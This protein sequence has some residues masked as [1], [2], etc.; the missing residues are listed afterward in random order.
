MAVSKFLIADL[1]PYEPAVVR[2]C[3]EYFAKRF[4]SGQLVPPI[5]IVRFDG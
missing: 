3:V 5:K 1:Y 4:T 2:T